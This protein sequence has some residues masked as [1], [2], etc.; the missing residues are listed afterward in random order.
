MKFWI[1]LVILGLPI[2]G[3]F[4]LMATGVVMVYRASKILTLAQGGIGMFTAYVL[5]QLNN[6]PATYGGKGWDLPIWIALPGAIA[7]AA[8]LGYVI[9]RFLLRPLRDRPVLVSVIM[10]V[11]V[12][13][14]LTAIA[15]IVWGYDRQQAPQITP[16]GP[17]KFF[18]IT[19]GQSDVAI[20]A[21]TGLILLFILY[22]FKYTTLGIS[23]RAVADDRRAALLMG[24]PADR[25]SALSWIIGSVLAGLAGIL[26]S[27]ILQLQP[28]NLT[29]ISIPAYAAALFGGLTNLGRMVIGAT[30]VGI[31]YSVVP[32]LPLAKTNSLPGE[33]ELAIFGAV[34]IFMFL[35]SKTVQL[36]EEEI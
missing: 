4:A 14:L 12:L 20:L 24:V 33:R 29:L 6:D 35:T 10:T 34:I 32:D 3:V 8:L 17:V 2:A 1:Q 18:G 22:L 26:L 36:Q 16:E 15:G 25:V 13:A 23:M 7:F 21:A 9:E 5:Y 19:V 30:V 27:P 11:G 31:L 28:L